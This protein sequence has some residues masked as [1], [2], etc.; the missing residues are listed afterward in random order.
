MKKLRFDI[1]AFIVG[2]MFLF[3]YIMMFE[4]S[5]LTF[6]KIL[7]TLYFLAATIC[8]SFVLEDFEEDRKWKL[9]AVFSRLIYLGLY[10]IAPIYFIYLLTR[11]KNAEEDTDSLPENQ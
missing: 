3:V 11:G 5:F 9:P 6:P 1:I 7:S 2:C 10:L 8:F 4:E